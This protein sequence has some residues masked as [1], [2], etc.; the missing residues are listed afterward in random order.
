MGLKQDCLFRLLTL[1][2]HVLV[3]RVNLQ[4][5]HDAVA[6]DEEGNDG[7]NVPFLPLYGLRFGV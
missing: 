3:H 5:D 6:N 7:L 1:T 4:P 2:G